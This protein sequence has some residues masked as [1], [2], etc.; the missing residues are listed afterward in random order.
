[1]ARTRVKPG[2][3][4]VELRPGIAETAPNMKLVLLWH[5]HQPPYAD[6]SSGQHVMPW[7][8]MH[9]LKDYV[10]MVQTVLDA[11]EG[12]RVTINLTP[13][14]LEQVEALVA[15]PEV[16]R[17]YTLARRDPGELTSNERSALLNECLSVHHPTMLEPH[18]RYRAL[19]AKLWSGKSMTRQDVLDLTVWFH[20]AWSGV[21]LRK[22]P[23]VAGLLRKNRGFSLEERDALLD[24]QVELVAKTIPI[25]R[26]GL[27]SGRLELSTSPFHHPILP[28]LCATESARE[29]DPAVPLPTLRFEYPGDVERH[30]ARAMA[31]H[32]ERFGAAPAGMWPSEGAVSEE[33]VRRMGQHGVRWIATD[34]SILAASGHP[35]R[36]HQ[37]WALGDVAIF[38]RDHKLSDRIGFVYSNLA[39]ELAAADFVWHVRSWAAATADPDAVLTVALDGENAWEHFPGGGYDFLSALYEQLAA[40]D[41]IE[42]ITPS[43]WLDGGGRPLELT[44]LTAGTWVDGTFRTWIGDPVKNRAW[45]VLAAARG[46]LAG[47]PESPGRD[48]AMEAM[49]R[50]EASDWF[51][52]FGAGHSSMHDAVFDLLFRRHVGAVYEELGVALPAVLKEP[53]TPPHGD[54]TKL[55]PARMGRPQITGDP[56]PYYEWASAA[57]SLLQQGAIHRTEPIMVE[58]MAIY[59]AS[60]LSLRLDTA[61]PA[62]TLLAD[63]YEFELRLGPPANTVLRIRADGVEGIYDE[64]ACRRIVELRLPLDTSGGPHHLRFCWRVLRNGELVDRFPRHGELVLTVLGPELELRNWVV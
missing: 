7:V 6:P 16:D 23:F 20:L 26:R 44:R 53:L 10:D 5:Q 8:R 30:L 58:A 32:A 25:H 42:M 2:P 29:N 12:V 59:D 24:R 19:R 27:E 63:G 46:V 1:M 54:P 55:E 36:H 31:F 43:M 50:A 33:A 38:F 47:A 35:D 49:L 9:A 14:L 51:W 56:Y 57:R 60:T 11:P 22:D 61:T 64:L 39:P 13:T 21:T 40:A 15:E 17:M 48:R 4:P 45:E 37:V 41:D 3:I 52:W 34:E 28:L 62:E 18:T